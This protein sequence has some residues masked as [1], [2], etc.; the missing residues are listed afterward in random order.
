M[1]KR[2]RSKGRTDRP[3]GPPSVDTASHRTASSRGVIIIGV[4]LVVGCA[5][6]L[7]SRSG[8][9]KLLVPAMP[10]SRGAGS[11]FN[12][13]LFTLDTLRADHLRCY[14]NQR[15]ETPAL[16]GLA[17]EGVRFADA[18]TPV[19][20]TLPSHC[21]IFTGAYPPRHGVRDNGT[22]RLVA[23]QTTL[24]ERL[25]AAGYSTAAFVAS[26]VLDKRYGLDQGFDFYEDDIKFRTPAPG[27]PAGLAQRPGNEVIDLASSWLQS[28]QSTEPGRPFFAWIHLF[29]PHLAHVPPEPFRTRYASNLYDGEVAFTDHQVGRFLDQLREFDLLDKTI[30]VVIG[31]HGEGLGE[32]GETAHSLLIY[33][34]TMHVPFIVWNP[35]VIPQGLV[36]DDRVVT[37]VDLVPTL[38]DLLGLD[39]PECDGISLIRNGSDSDRAIYLETMATELNH[40]WSPLFGLRRHRDKFIDAPKPE[41]YD[42]ARDPGELNNLLASRISVADELQV[43]LETIVK[44]FPAA[45]PDAS[46]TPDQQTLRKLRAIGYLGGQKSAAGTTLLDPKDMVGMWERKIATANKLVADG[47]FRESVPFLKELLNITLQDPGLWALLSRAQ[48]QAGR[49]EDAIESGMHAVDLQPT[50]ANHWIHVARLRYAGGDL[51]GAN[52][53]LEDAE[54]ID[55]NNGEILLTQAVFASAAGQHQEAIDLCK[56]ARRRD[57]GIQ[58]AASAFLGKIYE[59]IRQLGAAAEAYRQAVEAD[60]HQPAALLGLARNAGR[61][62]QY[63]RVVEF[64]SRIRVG[65]PEWLASRLLLAQSYIAIEQ[66]ASAERVLRE[67][68]AVAPKYPNAHQTLGNLLS[69]TDRSSEAAQAYHEAVE[70]DPS[71]ALTHHNLGVV[72]RD[73]G[74]ID[75]AVERFEDAVRVDPKMP[76]ALL[77]LAHIHAARGEIEQGLARL[78]Q[79]IQNGLATREQLE[80]DAALEPLTHD[81]RF[82]EIVESARQP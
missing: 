3:D 56:Q 51:E 6:Y 43:L 61:A 31:D 35:A 54:R 76:Q 53:D 41:Y 82:L 65:P 36:V 1:V 15:V 20:M 71:N 37:T 60:P 32:H 25:K 63:Q 75:A 9:P 11:G 12:V 57:P 80:A 29:D 13:V 42:L 78:S 30:V 16:D 7:Y 73:Q 33:E 44:T 59:E 64:V 4:L 19:P 52:G 46:V 47:N 5:G 81:L 14:G 67:L 2:R 39:V 70:L 66:H 24:A 26:F 74:Q 49:T 58:A 45:P 21:S 69:L 77:A 48:A 55:P 10:A 62:R 23:S 79:M 27:K 50:D 28:H 40:G 68:I 72:L 18:V 8:A 17:A 22:F 38:L 34:S